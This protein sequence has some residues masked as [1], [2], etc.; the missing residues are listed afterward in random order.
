V[1]V[2]HTALGQ[3]DSVFSWLDRAVQER[4]HWLVW[5]RRDPRWDQV[6]GDPR[7]TVL[8]H[9]LNLPP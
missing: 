7:Y 2:V 3:P 5:L 8:V 6:R 9:R 4:T 1:A